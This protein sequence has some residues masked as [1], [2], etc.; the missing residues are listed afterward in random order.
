MVKRNLGA[1]IICM[2]CSKKFR[3]IPHRIKMNL[4]LCPHCKKELTT[5]Y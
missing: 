4:Y 1:T 5:L 2:E 3:A